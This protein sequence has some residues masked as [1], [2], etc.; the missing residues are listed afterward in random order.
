MTDKTVDTRW[1]V[2]GAIAVAIFGFGLAHFLETLVLAYPLDTWRM[3]LDD[4]VTTIAA[5][6]VAGAAWSKA[7]RGEQVAQEAKA[8][9]NANGNGRAVEE[10]ALIHELEQREE[11]DY[12][13]LR[14]DMNELRHGG[15]Q[16][17]KALEQLTKELGDG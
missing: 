12:Q 17:R 8:Q 2:G 14:Q 11:T 9:A 4:L 1:L 16:L 7:H 10:V 3:D 5:L 13:L 15:E 6:V